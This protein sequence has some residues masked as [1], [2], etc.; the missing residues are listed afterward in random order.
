MTVD[1]SQNN[2]FQ[3]SDD[4]TAAELIEQLEKFD[5]SPGQFLTNLLAVHCFMAQANSGAILHV[6]QNRGVD[7]LALYPHLEKAA[8]VP[9]WLVRSAKAANKVISSN[10]VAVEPLDGPNQLYS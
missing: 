4:K 1:H 2:Q 5:G 8:S 7:V 9:E 3:S 6:N 10:T